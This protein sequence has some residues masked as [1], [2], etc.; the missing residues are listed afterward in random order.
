VH[1]AGKPI[2]MASLSMFD[3]TKL[4]ERV[5]TPAQ[6]NVMLVPVALQFAREKVCLVLLMQ[7][8]VTASSSRG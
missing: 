8:I 5:E 4:I 2:E 7:R 6:P 1:D 3:Y